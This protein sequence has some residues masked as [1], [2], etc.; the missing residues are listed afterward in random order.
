MAVILSDN[1]IES[2]LGKV[3]LNGD[4]KLINPNNINLRLG[5]IIL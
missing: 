2:I 5:S 1:Q 3:I 4:V